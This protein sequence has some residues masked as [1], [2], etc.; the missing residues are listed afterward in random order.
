MCAGGAF[1]I[2]LL[3][4]LGFAEYAIQNAQKKINP[5]YDEGHKDHLNFLEEQLQSRM[6]FYYI[7][8][9]LLGLLLEPKGNALYGILGILFPYLKPDF[10]NGQIG[11]PRRC[12][13]TALSAIEGRSALHRI[14]THTE[15]KSFLTSNI[16]VQ[17]A[18]TYPGILKNRE[19]R[20]CT[21]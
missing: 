13:E 2:D 6:K 12:N 21:S 11:S 10:P 16:S 9:L 20:S 15:Q 1:P 5:A 18:Y 4:F 19:S 3:I 14:K 8:N 7:V 17:H